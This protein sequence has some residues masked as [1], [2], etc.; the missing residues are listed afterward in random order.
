MK[1]VNGNL[2]TMAKAGQFDVI[3][4]GANC[5]HTMGAGIA[6]KIAKE[7]P[8]ALVADQ[9]TPYGD[10]D[11]LGTISTV[12]TVSKEG[13]PVVVVN[14]YTQF[15]TG[16][17]ARLH[18]VRSAFSAVREWCLEQPDGHLLRIGYPAVGCGIG[19]LDMEDVLTV[20]N[21]EMRGMDH[22]LVIYQP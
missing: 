2:I 13:T 5:F 18:A 4:H 11:K 19:G 17:Q 10:F 20:I 15:M 16:P 1:Q 6:E 7:Y 3:I 8:E 9:M 22:T 14:A 21:H 12:R